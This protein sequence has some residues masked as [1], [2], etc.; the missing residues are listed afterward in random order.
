MQLN[1]QTEKNGNEVIVR[2]PFSPSNNE[3][4]RAVGGRWNPADKAWHFQQ[5][6]AVALMLKHLFGSPSSPI[7][8]K[9]PASLC[10]DDGNLQIGGY[11][12]AVRPLRDSNVQLLPGVSLIE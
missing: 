9:I 12:L 10:T 3:Q 7:E 2:C 4:F 5:T 1:L 6:P 11:V 8:V